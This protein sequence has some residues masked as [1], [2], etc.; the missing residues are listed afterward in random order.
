ME[1]WSQRFEFCECRLSKIFAFTS[2]VWSLKFEKFYLHGAVHGTKWRK[3]AVTISIKT[4]KRSLARVYNMKVNDNLKYKRFGIVQY[5]HQGLW[6]WAV[7]G[8]LFSRLLNRGVQALWRGSQGCARHWTWCSQYTL[9]LNKSEKRISGS[10][11]N[12]PRTIKVHKRGNR[13]AGFR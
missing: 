1:F 9:L 11:H 3:T 8:W 10:D 4:K 7:V 13:V 12:Q 2:E 5:V 6:V